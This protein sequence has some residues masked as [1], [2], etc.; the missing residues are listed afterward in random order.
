ML[1]PELQKWSAQSICPLGALRSVLELLGNWQRNQYHTS[2]EQQLRQC[3]SLHV[4]PVNH[5]ISWL[6][7]IAQLRK[8]CEFSTIHQGNAGC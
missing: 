8:V 6:S 7:Y 1:E 2:A 3:M 4:P 5:K